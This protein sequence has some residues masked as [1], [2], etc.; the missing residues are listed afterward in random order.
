MVNWILTEPLKVERLTVAIADLPL[1]LVGLKLVLL[2]DFHYDGQRLS[3]EL[4]AEVITT[5]NQ[6]NPDLI[7]L[8]GDY[9][10][11][12]PEPINDLIVRLKYLKSRYGIYA[13]LGNH[14]IYH[15]QAKQQVIEAFSRIGIRVLWN[16]IATPLGADL[17]IIGLAEYWS[18]QFNPASVMNRVDPSIP[19]LVLCHNPDTA[20]ILKQWRVDLQ[21]SG[22]THGGQIVIPGIGSAPIL[23]QYFR[24]ITPT[25][26]QRFIPYLRPCSR[27][28]KNWQWSEGLHQVGRNQLY[29][30][31]GLGTYFP[32]RFFCPPELTVIRL[33]R[34]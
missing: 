16:A 24:Q 33:D 13:C 3:E 22:H 8:T 30:N 31:R 6:E 1:S 17:P 29:V 28:V 15:P 26:L 21:L 23:L 14:D 18:N 27:I 9:I 4:L 10:T 5:S 7:L 20:V 2:S 34:R 32:G 25:C 12:A 11:Y 19:R